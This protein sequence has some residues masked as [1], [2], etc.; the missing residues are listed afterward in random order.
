MNT[1]IYAQKEG[2]FSIAVFE[3]QGH[4]NVVLTIGYKKKDS[5]EWTNA[6][7]QWEDKDTEKVEKLIASTKG[8]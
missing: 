7:V 8:K 3:N 1:P 2:R 5:D 6:R 4:K